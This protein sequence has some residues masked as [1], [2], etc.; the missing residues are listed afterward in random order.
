MTV[1]CVTLCHAQK[2]QAVVGGV[3]WGHYHGCFTDEDF[4][5][6]FKTYLQL[7]E[8]LGSDGVEE[9]RWLIDLKHL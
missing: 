8:Y 7:F 4:G 1:S 9:M 5:H 6:S 2:V 3:S